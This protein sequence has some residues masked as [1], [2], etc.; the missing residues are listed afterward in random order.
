[1]ISPDAPPYK[2][3]I[4][5]LVGLLKEGFSSLGHQV[6]LVNP[7]IRLREFKFSTIP[8]HRYHTKYDLIH[9]HGPTP[10][11][12]DLTLMINKGDKVV[13]THHAEISWFSERL[14][15]VYRNFHRFLTKRARAIIVHSYDYARLFKG[16]NVTVIRMPCVFKPSIGFN[17]KKKPNPFVVLYVG[18]FR[19]FKGIDL[20]IKTASVLKDANFFLVGDGYLKHKLMSMARNLSNVK[21]MDTVSDD[22]LSR[23]YS[24]AHVICLP[25]INTTE[26]Y[27]LV[28]IEGALHG[29]VPIASNLIG[30]RENVFQLRGILF[31]PGSYVSLAEKVRMLLSERELW[32]K[33]AEDSQKAA[34]RYVNMYNPEY[35]VKKHE[36]VFSQCI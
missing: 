13:Y 19:S 7:K 12:S 14:S 20:L 5:R 23:L 26:A 34:F 10:L 1:M 31:E 16:M 21:F 28:L 24:S 3:G 18:Q 6:V 25:S 30:V 15:K 2:G 36:E 11:L 22:E 33:L 29:C 17:I 35:Y 9:V 27:G 8:F 4:S 32:L